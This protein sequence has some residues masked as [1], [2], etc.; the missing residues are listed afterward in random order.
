MSDPWSAERYLKEAT[1]FCELAERANVPMVRDYY[2]SVA[3]RYL[4]RAENQAWM[5]MINH[6]LGPA[7]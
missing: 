6:R 5:A 1:D 7:R 3:Q 4:T 2:K